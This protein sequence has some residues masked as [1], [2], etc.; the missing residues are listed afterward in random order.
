MALNLKVER[1]MVFPNQVWIKGTLDGED[2]FL[3]TS[4]NF[5]AGKLKIPLPYTLTPNSPITIDTRIQISETFNSDKRL[6]LESNLEANFSDGRIQVFPKFYENGATTD[7]KNLFAKFRE[8][9]ANIT[10]GHL[11]EIGSS[12]STGNHVKTHYLPN[13][14]SY[15]GIDIRSGKNVDVVGDVHELS[16]FVP[17]N[18]FDGV[19]SLSVFEHIMMPWKV[20]IEL[21]KVMKIGGVGIIYTHQAWPIHCAPWDYWRFSEYAWAAL[22]NKFTGF[23]ILD[24]EMA[25][26]AAILPYISNFGNSHSLSDPTYQVSTVLFRKIGETNLSWPVDL[27]A[28]VS[29]NY[30]SHD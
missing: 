1:F 14:W 6:Y 29:G 25:E 15:T 12:G 17:A 28:I 9:T 26:P 23:E 22:F 3:I 27:N 7:P 5:V 2:R 19:I 10:G 30:P 24:V 13:G 11:L 16:Q 20:V 18:Q 4:L 21:N 8:L